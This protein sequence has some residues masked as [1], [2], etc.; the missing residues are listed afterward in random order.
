VWTLGDPGWP[1]PN[2]VLLNHALEQTGWEGGAL[3]NET[4]RE[5]VR[6]RLRDVSWEA[7]RSDVRPFLEGSESVDLLDHGNLMRLLGAPAI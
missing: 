1:E 3:T 6:A 4:W 7:I 5:A 2:L